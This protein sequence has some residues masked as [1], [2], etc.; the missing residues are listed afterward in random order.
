MYFCLKEGDRNR[1]FFYESIYKKKLII[2]NVSSVSLSFLCDCWGCAYC[3]HY[4]LFYFLAFLTFVIFSWVK[5]RSIHFWRY[6]FS[7]YLAQK[8]SVLLL[9]YYK[10]PPFFNI[11]KCNFYRGKRVFT[12]FC[13]KYCLPEGLL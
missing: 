8:K 7:T 13:F 4:H 10:F 3:S 5:S 1:L 2:N 6:V 11:D 9:F 12:F